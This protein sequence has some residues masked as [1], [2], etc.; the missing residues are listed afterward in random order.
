MV[1]G[2]AVQFQEASEGA[3]LVNKAGAKLVLPGELSSVKD[4]VDYTTYWLH[5]HLTAAEALEIWERRMRTDS[6]AIRLRVRDGRIHDRK[7]A[8]MKTTGNVGQVDCL[9]E[10]LVVCLQGKQRTSPHTRSVQSEHPRFCTMRSPGGL[11][12]GKLS[13]ISVTHTSPK[14]QFTVA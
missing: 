1:Q 6:H 13:S 8:R 7:I 11:I 14:S 9:H 5:D 10:R 2:K 4:G 12:N 3:D